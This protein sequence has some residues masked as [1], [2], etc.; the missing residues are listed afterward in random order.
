MLKNK[1][2][3]NKN[4]NNQRSETC[5]GSRAER[6]IG[7]VSQ[8]VTNQEQLGPIVLSTYLRSKL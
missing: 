6:Q 1:N 5:S 8:I 2:E 3:N 7:I 4:N